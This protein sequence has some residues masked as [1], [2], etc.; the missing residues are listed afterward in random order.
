M[1]KT[2]K[3]QEPG[4]AKEPVRVQLSLATQEA[5]LVIAAL[6]D[7]DV[8]VDLIARRTP[9]KVRHAKAELAALIARISDALDE[10][11]K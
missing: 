9:M 10:A 3:T 1:P 5:E 4:D 7:Q 8:I 6:E 11:Q 2:P